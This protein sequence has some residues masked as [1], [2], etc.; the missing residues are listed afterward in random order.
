MAKKY[1]SLSELY[2][3][4]SIQESLLQQYRVIF[5]TMES[6]FFAA[7]SAS[8]A[9][10]DS[11]VTFV[12]LLGLGIVTILLWRG[13][14]AER[15][16]S[17][18]FAQSLI[19]RAEKG[20]K[21]YRPTNKIKNM[22]DKKHKKDINHPMFTALTSGYTRNK[23]EKRLPLYFSVAWAILCIKVSY[24]D[25]DKAIVRVINCITTL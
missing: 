16:K 24:P 10:G 15:G 19:L 13:I 18:Y 12:S 7:A 25:L 1:A 20:E 21:I 3:L 8:V 4:W 22:K 11:A 2:S 5:I 6:I 23:M 17:V 9:I 14:C